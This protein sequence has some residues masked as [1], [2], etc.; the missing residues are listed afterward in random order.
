MTDAKVYM[1]KEEPLS[2]VEVLQILEKPNH[3]KLTDRP[4]VNPRHGSVY[5]FTYK[6]RHEAHKD[7]RADQYQWVHLGVH[8]L[9]RKNPKLKK[10]YHQRKINNERVNFHRYGYE[11]KDPTIKIVV[12]H[13]LGKADLSIKEAAQGNM[14]KFPLRSLVLTM[15]TVLSNI[16]TQMAKNP[17]VIPKKP[18]VETTPNSKHMMVQLPKNVDQMT[19]QYECRK[20]KISQDDICS[21]Y[22]LHFALENFVKNYGLVPEFNVVLALP[23]IIRVFEQLCSISSHPVLY[24]DTTFHV[25]DFYVTPLLF[26]CTFF[27]E[28]PCIP[29]AAIIHQ[30]KNMNVHKSF[31]SRL[32][33]VIPYINV[34]NV[35]IVTDRE[36][37]ISQA[38]QSIVPEITHVV[39]WN[40]LQKDVESWV[41]KHQRSK[42]N[43]KVYLN[44]IFH[45]LDCN[46]DLAFEKLLK[47]LKNKWSFPFIDYFESELKNDIKK[48]GKWV[49]EKLGLYRAGSGVT[50]NVP[51]GMNAVLKRLSQWREVSLRQIVLAVYFLQTFYQKEILAG[52]CGTGNYKLERNHG[53]MQLDITTFRLKYLFLQTQSSTFIV[54]DLQQKAYVVFFFP[55]EKSSCNSSHTYCKMLNI[56]KL[57]IHSF[58]DHLGHV[59][60]SIPLSSS[61]PHLD[62]H[63][64]S[65]RTP[66]KH[67]STTM[68]EGGDGILGVIGS[69]PPPPNTAS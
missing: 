13:Y 3:E 47:T 58:E 23:A 60:G 52:R 50:T 55:E 27:E 1:I 67:V 9:P 17:S 5:L 18:I 20:R 46:S 51:E 6:D 43:I 29:L 49:T 61:I 26:R 7:W 64:S 36:Q 30:G 53:N 35:I 8:S 44:H 38:I 65:R 69:I 4:A 32:V 11:H 59:S 28:E 41:T 14:R 40:H 42:T 24:Y 68:F 22:E 25:G 33:E 34:S 15:P 2:F 54:M 62:H 10:T 31:F 66:P 63:A 48:S 12:V 37:A 57:M 21:V 39:C 56:R 45:L 16:P 19:N